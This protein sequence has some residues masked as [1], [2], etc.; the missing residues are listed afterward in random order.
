MY[1]KIIR[2]KKTVDSN[3]LGNLVIEWTGRLDRNNS[4][5]FFEVVFGKASRLASS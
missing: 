2:E 4:R 1:V 3:L 5:L